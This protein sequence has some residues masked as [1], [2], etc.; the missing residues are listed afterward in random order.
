MRRAA[1]QI[2]EG[3]LKRYVGILVL[4]VCLS[5]CFSTSNPSP[6]V[7]PSPTPVI[8]PTPSPLSSFG[9]NTVSECTSPQSNNGTGTE[10]C[11]WTY[12]LDPQKCANRGCSKLV[13]YFAGGQ[14][15]CPVQGSTSYLAMFANDGYVAVCA[16]LFTTTDSAGS[17]GYPYSQESARVNLLVQNITS[18]PIIK[19]AWDGTKLLFSGVSHGSTATVI[20]MANTGYDATPSWQGSKFTGACFYD[21]FTTLPPC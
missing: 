20:A 11:L 9:Q 10:P 3:T 7:I 1:F 2:C 12:Q 6:Q 15:T 21:G 14:M 19:A 13:I 16:M 8:S 5:G 17:A 18:N 4:S